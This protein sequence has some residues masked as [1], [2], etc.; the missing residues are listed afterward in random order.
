MI[1][2]DSILNKKHPVK[3]VDS[4]FAVFI[5]FIGAILVSQINTLV[6]GYINSTINE[7][8]RTH[9]AIMESKANQV[10]K[11]IFLEDYFRY[12]FKRKPSFERE[13]EYKKVIERAK[14]LRS[15]RYISEGDNNHRV[16][17]NV[18]G[19]NFIS[20]HR[21]LSPTVNSYLLA[22][23]I[24]AMQHLF[25]LLPI[26]NNSFNLESRIYYVSISGF[27]ATTTPDENVS[28]QSI[29][30]TYE[31][32][33]SSKY[34]I[35]AM[36]LPKASQTN[37]FT[38]AYD[39]P[40]NEGKLITMFIPISIDGTTVGVLCFDFNIRKLG[41]LLSI[42]IDN[43][44]A[45][46]YFWIDGNANIIASDTPEDFTEDK[47]ITNKVLTLAN[48]HETGQF[49]DGFNFVTYKK[50]KGEYGA[51]FVTHSPLQVLRSEY[52]KQIIFVLILWVFFTI[53]LFFSY[54]LIRK[55]I[56]EMHILQHSL[57]W[58]ASHDTLTNVFNRNGFYSE[59]EAVFIK[60]ND[61]R[62]PIA[63]IQIDLDK[64]KSINDTYGH[65]SG[66][67][68]LIN[69]ASIIKENIREE[70]I[71]GRLGGEEFCIFCY[72]I[73]LKDSSIL[74]EKIRVLINKNKVEV[75]NDVW[76][77]VSASFGVSCSSEVNSYD[78]NKLQILA[79]K[80]LYIAK[81]NGRNRVCNT[82]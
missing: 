4:I 17:V 36:K 65:F 54:V 7:M 39:G 8:T 22:N 5:I 61:F 48:S 9:E 23:E 30:S 26:T 29:E 44:Y 74:A 76:I 67:E 35:N 18:I 66:D 79:D 13:I 56:K 45:G 24:N 14:G 49:R 33:I 41:T 6:G 50:V 75:L 20:K 53:S 70:D 47:N 60:L 73:D 28:A 63:I 40:N 78:I 69:T 2:I 32:M 25:S 11:I 37:I 21:T 16:I 62:R 72:D 3:I 77:N 80:R 38:P 81:N 71:L 12:A 58:K 68:V 57:K 59:L 15:F 31:R 51:I 52:G 43:K 82:G 34:F 55:L 46:N 19:N 42:A 1:L 64:F 10:N 27:Y